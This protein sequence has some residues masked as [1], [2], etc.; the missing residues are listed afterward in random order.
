MR[1][2]N[3]TIYLILT[4]FC[5]SVSLRQN[6]FAQQEIWAKITAGATRQ[7]IRLVAPGFIIPANCPEALLTMAKD[8]RQIMI[9]NLEILPLF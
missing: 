7:R 9:D 8:I 2:K 4:S 3:F 1:I 5:I 6:L